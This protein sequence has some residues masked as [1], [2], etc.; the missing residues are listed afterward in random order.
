MLV[1]FAAAVATGLAAGNPA[2]TVMW[3]ALIVMLVCY[4][5]GRIVGA[6]A[7]KAVQDYID[8]YKKQHPI[9]TDA[10]KPGEEPDEENSGQTEATT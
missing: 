6:I 9:P 7:H 8:Q 5:V 2:S 1:A 10:P 3:R 4:P